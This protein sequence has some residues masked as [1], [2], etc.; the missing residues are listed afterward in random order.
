MLAPWPQ[1]VSSLGHQC[2][3]RTA[4]AVYIPVSDRQ[5][6]WSLLS[7][8]QEHPLAHF[9]GCFDLHYYLPTELHCAP[10][11]VRQRLHCQWNSP[12][13]PPSSAAPQLLLVA[14]QDWGIAH[15]SPQQIVM[16]S[17]GSVALLGHEIGHWLGLVDEYAMSPELAEPFCHGHY[18]HPSLNVVVT[19]QQQM[20]ATEL[21]AI[22]KRLPWHRAV[23]EWQQLGVEQEDGQWQLGSP[24]GIIGLHAVATCATV[25]NH[26]AWRPVPEM[27]PMQYHDIGVWPDLYLQLSKPH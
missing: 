9:Y 7:A 20:T 17:T 3:V 21:Q 14:N 15:S 19:T 16:P 27:T 5:A 22:W 8:W 13:S 1:S 24:E 26:Y 25:P 4:T 10:Q 11:G 18:Q 2:G 12:Q 23:S 6:A